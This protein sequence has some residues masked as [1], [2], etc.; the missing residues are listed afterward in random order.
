M[1]YIPQDRRRSLDEHFFGVVNEIENEGELNYVFMR[2]LVLLLKKWG[3][4]YARLNTMMG[5]LSCVS[6]EFYRRVVASYE[7]AKIS[8]NGD[9]FG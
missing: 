1:P 2:I 6:A 4:N 8:E 9:L 7:A 3:V 5:V